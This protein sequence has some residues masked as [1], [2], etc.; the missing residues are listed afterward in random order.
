M[1]SVPN[2]D[3]LDLGDGIAMAKAVPFPDL[4][5]LKDVSGPPFFEK[6]ISYEVNEAIIEYN[7]QREKIVKDLE[8]QVADTVSV[9]NA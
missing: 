2:S 1:Q 8:D 3:E 4:T 5:S 6:L 7:K 9:A